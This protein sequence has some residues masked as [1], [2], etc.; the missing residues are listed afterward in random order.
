MLTDIKGGTDSNTIIV[1]D[2]NT[3]LTSKERSARQKIDRETQALNDTL[4]QKDII[5][6]H[7]AFHPKAAEYTLF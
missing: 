1:R 2:C 3:L 5:D 4:D 7:R 6:I